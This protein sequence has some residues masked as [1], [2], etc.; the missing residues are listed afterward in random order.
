MLKRTHLSLWQAN[1]GSNLT[2]FLL[3][4]PYLD[5]YFQSIQGV[6]SLSKQLFFTYLMQSL[7]FDGL[8]KKMGQTKNLSQ[9]W[10]QLSILYRPGSSESD[11]GRMRPKSEILIFL[12]QT[13]PVP[14]FSKSI[15]GGGPKSTIFKKVLLCSLPLS[16]Y[17]SYFNTQNHLGMSNIGII[18]HTPI[19]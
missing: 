7:T 16:L 11:F 9:F 13:M 19:E 6:G 1:E 8:M 12:A 10:H 17:M 2:D 14:I 18:R 5:P 3:S 4:M 15:G